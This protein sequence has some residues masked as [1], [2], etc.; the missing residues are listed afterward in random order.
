MTGPGGAFQQKLEAKLQTFIRT[1][2]MNIRIGG[3]AKRRL[4]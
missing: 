1:R 4:S 2:L 3:S